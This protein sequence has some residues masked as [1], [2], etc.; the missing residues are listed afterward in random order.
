MKWKG[1]ILKNNERKCVTALINSEQFKF[2]W[3]V[4][5][6]RTVERKKNENLLI[7]NR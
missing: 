1:K 5:V 6:F 3:K 7:P 4:Y 2:S